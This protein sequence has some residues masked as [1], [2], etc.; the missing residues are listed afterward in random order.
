MPPRLKLLI[1]EDEASSLKANLPALLQA[2]YETESVC[3]VT[4]ALEMLAVWR[5]DL[6]LADILLGEGFGLELLRRVRDQHLDCEV[7]MFTGAPSVESAIQA[8]RGGAADYLTEPIHLGPLQESLARAAERLRKS[9]RR[10]QAINL[11]EAGLQQF[12]KGGTGP[13]GNGGNGSARSGN[14]LGARFRLGLVTLDSDRKVLEVD[15]R[16][17]EATPTEFEILQYLFRNPER[18]IS[19]EELVQALRGYIVEAWEA[20]EILRPHISNLRRKMLD[21]SPQADVIVTVRSAG[22]MLQQPASVPVLHG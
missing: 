18:V 8:L 14:P 4:Q 6:V 12:I 1:V 21:V 16:S 17:V 11:V 7:I 22:Y 5:P 15:D 13:L 3:S 19:A 2:G 10:R 9:R 20:R